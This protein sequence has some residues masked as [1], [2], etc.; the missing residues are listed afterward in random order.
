MEA[1]FQIIANGDDVT[2]VIQDRV[3]EIRTVDKP[4]LDVDEC[5]ITL[6]DRDGRIR[7][8]PKGATVKVS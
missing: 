3:M 5:T 7:F 4:G 8:P 1:I 6:D 2:K